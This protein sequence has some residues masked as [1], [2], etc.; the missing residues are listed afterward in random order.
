MQSVQLLFGICHNDDSERSMWVGLMN[1]S[2]PIIDITLKIKIMFLMTGGVSL[3]E[4][5]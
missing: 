4:A 2:L 3:E 1:T 5:P